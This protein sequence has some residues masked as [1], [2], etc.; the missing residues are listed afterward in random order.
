[1]HLSVLIPTHRRSTDLH[2]CL[3]AL[4]R[5]RRRADQVV[6]I[7][8]RD[9]VDTVEL[10]QS[11]PADPLPLEVC[12]SPTPGVVAALNTGLREGRGDVLAMI[13]DDTAPWPDWLERI[14][15]HFTGTPRLGGLGGRDVIRA[16]GV[17][18]ETETPLVGRVRWYGRWVGQ[19]H[20]GIGP[21]REVELLKGC[22]MSYRRAAIAGLSFDDRL[23]GNGAQW[24]N[25]SAFSLAVKRAGWQV[26]YDPSVRVDHYLGP[27]YGGDERQASTPSEVYDVVF[28]ETLSLLEYLNPLNRAAFLAFGMGIGTRRAPGLLQWVR[29]TVMRQSHG[30]AFQMAAWRARID[31]WR[32]F[33]RS[34]ATEARNRQWV[35][36]IEER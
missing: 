5:Q 36:E 13:D 22:N 30:A 26:V 23:R 27:R 19:A 9:D 14:E 31:A 25:D 4:K 20:R 34:A 7:V 6:V 16:D 10:L 35:T 3:E 1:V 29:S 32:L 28:N 17:A 8:R 18:V 24:F 12:E 15:A 2:R 33:R 11:Y 21:P